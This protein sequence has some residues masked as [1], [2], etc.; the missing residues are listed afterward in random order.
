MEQKEVKD[1]KRQAKYYGKN[2]FGYYITGETSIKCL[3]SQD[4]ATKEPFIICEG[5]ERL[6][7]DFEDP[8]A[9]K[10]PNGGDV[11]EHFELNGLSQKWYLKDA[12]RMG[13]HF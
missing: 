5:G 11:S 6:T 8:R 3:R 12:D 2:G 9:A 7:S 10:V 13:R 1:G 4:P